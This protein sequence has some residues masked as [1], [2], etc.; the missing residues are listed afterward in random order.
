M[1]RPVGHVFEDQK[2][3]VL[4]CTVAKQFHQVWRV[5]PAQQIDLATLPEFNITFRDEVMDE[6]DQNHF[7]IN[8]R[9]HILDMH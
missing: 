8:A 3:V 4:V 2:P 9:G 1:E 5:E 7:D 6:M